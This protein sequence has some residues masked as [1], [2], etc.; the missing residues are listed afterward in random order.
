M[1]E[2][3]MLVKEPNRFMEFTRKIALAYV[4][5]F[6]VVGDEL[7]KMFET[8]VTR[9][10]RMQKDARK[11]V[12]EGNKEVRQFAHDVQKEQK[13]A[14]VRANKTVKKAVKRVEGAIA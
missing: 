10:E 12:K 5:A 2:K 9:G 8:F 11:M 13:A 1:A 4:G 7:G 6:G 3:K 14:V